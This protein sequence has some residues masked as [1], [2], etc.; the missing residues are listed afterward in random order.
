[1]NLLLEFAI[2]ISLVVALGLLAASAPPSAVRRA[3]PLDAGGLDGRGIGDA[4]VD[5]G[6]AGMEA[7]CRS[8]R[9]RLSITISGRQPTSRRDA[10][11]RHHDK[12]RS[13]VGANSSPHRQPIDPKAIL[14]AI[15]IAGVVVNLA[16]LLIG[17]WRLR[18]DRRAGDDRP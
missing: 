9:S 10:A 16:G 13:G 15:W 1:M 4:A 5:A 8:A 11:N 12:R 18:P 14:L 2:K 6:C 3:A 17:F 7:A